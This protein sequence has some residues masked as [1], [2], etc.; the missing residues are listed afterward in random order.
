MLLLLLRLSDPFQK[1]G[2]W[3]KTIKPKKSGNSAG[4]ETEVERDIE[5]SK[6]A[7]RP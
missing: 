1:M 3:Q 4:P 5:S 7:K 6:S 2:A